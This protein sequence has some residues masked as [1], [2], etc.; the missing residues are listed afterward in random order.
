MCNTESAMSNGPF[1]MWGSF[2]N[3]I[4][5]KLLYT[6][7][8]YSNTVINN[9]QFKQADL[10][11]TN[12]IPDNGNCKII[13]STNINSERKVVLGFELHTF[14]TLIIFYFSCTRITLVLVLIDGWCT[15]CSRRIKHLF[16]LQI[17]KHVIL[18]MCIL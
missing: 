13:C 4:L 2:L 11:I 16:I 1:N 3:T 15:S 17:I 10:R 12:C 5:I 18:V 9:I 14:F 6:A 7:Y 8:I